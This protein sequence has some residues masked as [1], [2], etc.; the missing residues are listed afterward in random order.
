MSKRKRGD[1]T[2]SHNLD[3]LLPAQKQQR[4]G[5]AH[6]PLA[7]CSKELVRAFKTAQ[8]FERQKL[9]RRK[10]NA[11]GQDDIKEMMR[12]DSEIAALKVR[13]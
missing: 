5:G 4:R 3:D 10:R 13:L 2:Q 6:L 7:Q 1:D 11:A 12:I 8:G 9:G